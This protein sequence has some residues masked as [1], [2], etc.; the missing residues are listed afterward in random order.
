MS[1][2][3][4]VDRQERLLAREVVR[5]LRFAR[6]RQAEQVK[7]VLLMG[8]RRRRADA[9]RID[10]IRREGRVVRVDELAVVRIT[11]R[12]V[13][14]RIGRD[15]EMERDAG[16]QL[17]IELPI[18]VAAVV[19]GQIGAVVQRERRDRPVV[20]RIAEPCV[21][22]LRMIR[23]AAVFVAVEE[24][25]RRI[26]AGR[27]VVV[28]PERVGEP[29]ERGHRP[30]RRHRAR[31]A[32]LRVERL[33]RAAAER[34]GGL[35]RLVGG[36]AREELNDAPHCVVAERRGGRPGDHFDALERFGRQVGPRRDA[37]GRR[38]DPDAVDEHGDLARRRAADADRRGRAG[39]AVL[40][41]GHA[42]QRRE[43]LRDARVGGRQPVEILAREHLRRR[44]A[45]VE[46]FGQMPRVGHADR[47]QVRA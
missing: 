23:I 19:V 22:V 47:R 1:T 27:V 42:R 40:R 26:D 6:Q 33:V 7:P 35:V 18:R 38:A 4:N 3:G 20:A 41:D 21:E 2:G 16:R 37:G 11:E 5:E 43:R 25:P 9:L 34:H 13:E 28:Q 31:R 46:R 32:E 14:L 24:R 29:A 30:R 39:P 45:A 12:L 17:V 36:A 15:V 8:Q 10:L 44:I